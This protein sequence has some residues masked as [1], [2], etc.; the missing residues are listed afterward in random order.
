MKTNETEYGLGY[1]LSHN[2]TKLEILFKFPL[3]TEIPG[4]TAWAHGRVKLEEFESGHPTKEEI[5]TTLPAFVAS[6][7]PPMVKPG[8]AV[9]I[10][11]EEYERMEELANEPYADYDPDEDE[12]I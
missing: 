2:P 4:E 5:E 8:Q 10:T 6:G 11:W 3:K 7:F 9:L 12:E 1:R